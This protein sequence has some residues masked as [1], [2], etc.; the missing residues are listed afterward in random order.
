MAHGAELVLPPVGLPGAPGRALRAA[1]GLRPARLP[2]QRDAGL[3]ARRPRGLLDQPRPRALGDP[4]PDRRERRDRPAR[5]RVVGPR[6][7]HDLRLVRRPDQLHH[8]GGLPG[9]PRR[10]PPLVAGRPPRHRQGHRPVPHDRL[11]GDAVVGGHRRPAPRVG[12]R[13]HDRARREDEQEPRQLPRP[14]G[15]GRRVRRRR[16]AVRDAPRG[17][18]RPRRRR[19]LGL[20]RPPL[21]RGPRQ[22]LRQPAQPD[23]LDGQPVPRR[24]APGAAPGRRLAAGRGLGGHAAAV[25]GAPRGLSPERGARGAV[26][27][28]RRGEQDRRRR[29][30]VDAQ[31]GGPGGR[32]R[33]GR[34]AARRARRPRRGVPARRPRR[35]A[36]H[37]D[38]RAA[39]ARAARPPLRVRARTGTAG[40]R[41][42]I[43]S[44]GAPTPGRGG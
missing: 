32:R 26:G 28:R 20:V 30:A 27:V 1:P 21:Q 41:S 3:P 19:V 12:P 43:A 4:V 40:R 10:L 44:R 13:L 31:Q 6:G 37:A 5:G 14:G 16:D 39:R 23:G 9:R 7:G 2:A 24:R 38:H 18:V 29:T 33:G 17:P 8:R 42:S 35:G 15:D 22:R 34:E 11:A 36:V 25:R